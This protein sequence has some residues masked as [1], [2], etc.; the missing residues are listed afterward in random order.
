MKLI[1]HTANQTF[2][3]ET[4]PFDEKQYEELCNIV[5][6]ICKDPRSFGFDTAYGYVS[7]PAKMIENS[8]FEVQK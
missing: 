5:D 6:N 4:T 8:I 2:E 7:L 1:V 3:S